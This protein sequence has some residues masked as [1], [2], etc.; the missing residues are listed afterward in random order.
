MDPVSEN[1]APQTPKG[2][3]TGGQQTEG[4]GREPTHTHETVTHTHDHYHVTHHHRG[5]I[6]GVGEWEHRTSWHTHEHTHLPLTHSHD[7][8]R[9]DEAAHHGKEAHIHDHAHPTGSD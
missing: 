8:N 6:A 2:V 7:Y 5:G 4:E 9:E 3:P 1:A